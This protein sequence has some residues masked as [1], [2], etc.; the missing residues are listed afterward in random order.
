MQEY[1]LILHVKEVIDCGLLM[2]EGTDF[3][4]DND[5]DLRKHK[6]KT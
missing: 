6:F 1:N 2:M 4:P 3:Y 5:E